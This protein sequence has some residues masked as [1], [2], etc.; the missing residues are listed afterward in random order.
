MQKYVKFCKNHSDEKK[1]ERE[2]ARAMATIRAHASVTRERDHISGQ[3]Q[4]D[5]VR[6][7]TGAYNLQK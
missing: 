2:N 3:N 6:K 5:D 1:T 7:Q 4:L